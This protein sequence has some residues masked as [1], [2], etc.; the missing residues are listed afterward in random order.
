MSDLVKKAREL[1]GKASKGPWEQSID[2]PIYGSSYNEAVWGSAGP[3]HGLIADCRTFEPPAITINNAAFIAWARTG[4]PEL[5]DEIE[6][7]QD[8]SIGLVDYCKLADKDI[9]ELKMKHAKTET[10]LRESV[11]RWQEKWNVADR[12]L[13][14][15]RADVKRLTEALEGMLKTYDFGEDFMSDHAIAIARVALKDG[16]QKV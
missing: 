4:V 11:L 10:N 1:A 9:S 3:G 5:C 7:L 16:E 13:H 14:T 8:E 2:H 12:H 6:R 15:L